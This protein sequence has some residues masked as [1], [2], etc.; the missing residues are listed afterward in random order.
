MS[1]LFIYYLILVSKI[2]IKIRINNYLLQIVH[3]HY[4]IQILK[5]ML[6]TLNFI[7]KYFDTLYD[8]LYVG[9]TNKVI[10]MLYI[11]NVSNTY[12]TIVYSQAS[13]LRA[14]KF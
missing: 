9:K 8:P 13:S 5:A 4:N 2:V 11:A 12:H 3:T 14:R 1:D 10:Q 7:T 6:I